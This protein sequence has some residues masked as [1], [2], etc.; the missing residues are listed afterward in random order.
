MRQRAAK[1]VP[2]NAKACAQAPSLTVVHELHD[3]VDSATRILQGLPLVDNES[4][5]VEQLLRANGIL[6]NLPWP[7]PFDETLHR[8]C[9]GDA[10]NLTWIPEESVSFGGYFS[11]LLDAEDI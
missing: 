9:V 1:E 4:G 3:T 6:R 10:R 2:G 8:L 7:C 11:S 5:A